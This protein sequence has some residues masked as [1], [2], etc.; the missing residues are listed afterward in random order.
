S[1]RRSML[2]ELTEKGKKLAPIFHDLT[3][4]N[5]LRFFGG[6]NDEGCL[7]EGEVRSAKEILGKIL[8]HARNIEDSVKHAEDEELKK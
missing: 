8:K 3:H 1:D 4:E 2:I 5:Q 7:S 6:V